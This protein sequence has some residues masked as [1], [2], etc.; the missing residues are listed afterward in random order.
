MMLDSSA[1]SEIMLLMSEVRPIFIMR[2]P[3]EIFLSQLKYSI[4]RG[5]NPGRIK[6]SEEDIVTRLVKALNDPRL[7]WRGDYKTT[8]VSVRK[9]FS[10]ECFL[11]IP[12]KLEQHIFDSLDITSNPSTGFHFTHDV[13]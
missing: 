3:V 13:K 7:Y 11:S 1:L 2:D 4:A 12:E 10:L 5:N 9:R 8:L 6:L